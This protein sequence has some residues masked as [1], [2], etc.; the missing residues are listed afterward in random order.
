MHAD[1]IMQ[2]SAALNRYRGREKDLSFSTT[3]VFPCMVCCH[4]NHPSGKTARKRGGTPSAPDL[5]CR[6]FCDVQDVAYS[7]RKI[8][9]TRQPRD[10]RHTRPKVPAVTTA[11]LRMGTFVRID[12]WLRNRVQNRCF[13]AR[14]SRRP[15]WRGQTLELMDR[16][17]CLFSCLTLIARH[18]SSCRIKTWVRA[19]PLTNKLCFHTTH[20]SHTDA[21]SCRLV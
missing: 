13:S 20:P 14:S 21:F 4:Q 18:R 7:T 17:N 16:F 5:I 12:L 6:D 19:Y 9:G 8:S 2:C 11:C 15:R 3:H 1:G 10:I